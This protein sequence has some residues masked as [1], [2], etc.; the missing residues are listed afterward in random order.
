MYKENKNKDFIQQ[1]LLF[2]ISLRHTFTRVPQHIR[3][4]RLTKNTIDICLGSYPRCHPDCTNWQTRNIKAGKNY[5]VRPNLELFLKLVFFWPVILKCKPNSETSQWAFHSL[6]L[7]PPL[8]HLSCQ[9]RAE[10]L[11][12]GEWNLACNMMMMHI[13]L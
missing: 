1:F 10:R 3:V 12:A 6:I 9:L 5:S 7:A 13:A 4:V 11:E 2:H 8:P